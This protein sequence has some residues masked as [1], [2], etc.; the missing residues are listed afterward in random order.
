[1]SWVNPP[2]SNSD[3]ASDVNPLDLAN[4]QE[5]YQNLNPFFQHSS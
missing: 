1:M 5:L 4:R 2:I 3:S